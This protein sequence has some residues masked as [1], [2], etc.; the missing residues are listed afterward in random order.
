[1][2]VNVAMNPAEI[3]C[4]KGT[5]MPGVLCVVFDV[6]RATSSMVT[7]L[8]HGMHEI[9]PVETIEEALEWHRNSPGMLLAGERGGD[10]IEGFTLGNSP[11]EYV[12]HSGAR[13]VTTT[14]NGTVALRACVGAS[15]V[16][17]GAVL[18]LQAL[19]EAIAG[20]APSGLLL[21]CAGTFDTLAL[22]DVW[23]AGRLLGLLEARGV[24]AHWSDAAHTAAA[25]ARTW[26]DALAPLRAS[27][28]GRALVA[29]GREEDL[30]WC[31]RESHLPVVG[32]MVEGVIRG[33]TGREV[34]AG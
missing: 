24:A 28:N 20:R 30:E 14:T 16:W 25:V 31:A 34:V 2:K 33:R 5:A 9:I 17:V 4:L 15:E 27:R 18:N 21:V 19:A 26:P 23:A 1:M 7:G 10:R 3:A 8:A 6:L 32:C 12:G 11:R 13:V 22:E 29:A